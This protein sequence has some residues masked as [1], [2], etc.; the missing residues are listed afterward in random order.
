MSP[1]VLRTVAAPELCDRCCG[2]F[3]DAVWGGFVMLVAADFVTHV[4]VDFVTRAAVDVVWGGF[5]G[6]IGWAQA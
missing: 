2:G 6:M 4:A 5:H 3:C 1:R